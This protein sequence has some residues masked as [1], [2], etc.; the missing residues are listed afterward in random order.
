MRLEKY[1]VM[2][3]KMFEKYS[4]ECS[5]ILFYIKNDFSEMYSVLISKVFEHVYRNYFWPQI[6]IFSVMISGVLEMFSGMIS[7]VFSS[8]LLFIS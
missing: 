8:K 6:I 1:S 4:E 5:L 7:K 3:S 2:I